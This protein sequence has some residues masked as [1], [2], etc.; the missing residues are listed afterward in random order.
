MKRLRVLEVMVAV[1]AVLSI[2]R[3]AR[4]LPTRIGRNDFSHY[5]LAHAALHESANPYTAS[6]TEM[7]ARHGFEVDPMLAHLTDPPGLLWFFSWMHWLP[8]RDAFWVWVGVQIASLVAILAMTRQLIGDRLTA[9]TWRIVVGLVIASLPL[10]W[11]FYYSQS[12]LALAALVLAAYVWHRSGRSTAACVVITL[13]GTLKVFPWMLLPWFIWRSGR[14][15]R[16]AALCAGVGALTIWLTGIDRWRAFLETGVPTFSRYAAACYDCFSLPA[17]V[18]R[19]GAGMTLW[20]ALTALAVVAT[21]YALCWGATDREAEFCLLSTGMIA[22]N[23]V[24]WP[25]YFVWL[26]FPAIILAARLTAH[27]STMRALALALLVLLL[28]DLETGSWAWL[29]RHYW[30]KVLA[31]S[32]PLTGLLAVGVFFVREL[33]LDG[34]RAA[35]VH[36]AL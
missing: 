9:Q 22:A 36:R 5:Y 17:L 15:L 27:W 35:N 26:I 29:D 11:H 24:G 1:V 14:P 3:I 25:H 4:L 21:V 23:L 28:N 7:C 32:L 12:N 13:A 2:L 6:L 19:L 8:A 34:C 33:H 16:R 20:P 10:Y 30:L 31:N 18:A